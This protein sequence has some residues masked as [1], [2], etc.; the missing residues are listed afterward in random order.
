VQVK[1]IEIKSMDEEYVKGT[2]RKE[3]TKSR[4]VEDTSL[5]LQTGG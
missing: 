3:N 4:V 2:K 5:I 1:G